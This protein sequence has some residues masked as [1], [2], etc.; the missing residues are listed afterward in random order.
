MNRV[1][2][3]QWQLLQNKNNAYII[4]TK[5]N[6]GVNNILFIEVELI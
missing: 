2:L 5:I 3:Y 4:E 1:A 6:E